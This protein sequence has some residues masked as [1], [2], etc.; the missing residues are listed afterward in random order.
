MA[1]TSPTSAKYEDISKSVAT[2]S[3]CFA[4]AIVA[5]CSACTAAAMA[6]SAATLVLPSL[7]LNPRDSTVVCAGCTTQCPPWYASVI[8]T[9]PR[10][11]PQLCAITVG[12]PLTK[13]FTA[14]TLADAGIA[15]ND[16]SSAGAPVSFPFGKMRCEWPIRR[17]SMP[18]V[19]RW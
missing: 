6:G 19:L 12:T 9:M 3:G 10:R 7:Y 5:W 4:Y 16:G 13:P 2:P 14:S 15:A 18:V 11:R 1:E 8:L 17:A